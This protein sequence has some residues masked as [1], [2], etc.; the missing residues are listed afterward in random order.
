MVIY[1]VGTDIV[2][3]YRIKEIMDKCPSFAE[4][5]FSEEELD[6]FR[7]KKQKLEFA[8][9]RFAAKEAVSKS[10][11]TGFS[12][13]D[14]KDICVLNDK[15]GKPYVKLKNKADD[16]AKELGSYKIHISISHGRDNAVAYA[17]M[18]VD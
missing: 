16:I 1:G 8:C 4:K 10:M 3:M 18:E 12:G 7:C 9:G 14:I 2:E 17:I 15:N 5:I 13:F 6:I 11:G